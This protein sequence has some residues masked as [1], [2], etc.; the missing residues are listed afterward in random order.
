MLDYTHKYDLLKFEGHKETLEDYQAFLEKQLGKKYD[1]LG[2]FATII[3]VLRLKIFRWYWNDK[4]YCSELGQAALMF[5]K[6]RKIIRVV[7][8][9]GLYNQIKKLML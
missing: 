5:Y 2:A 1:V 4:W 9:Q 3:P 8:P 7:S 6:K